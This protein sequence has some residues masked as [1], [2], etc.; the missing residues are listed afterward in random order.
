MRGFLKAG[1]RLRLLR[2]AADPDIGHRGFLE[3]GGARLIWDAV[4]AAGAPSI[5]LGDRLYDVLGEEA[6][7]AFVQFTF[8]T[9][10]EDYIAARQSD[11]LIQD[12][13][14]AELFNHLKTREVRLLKIAADH[15]GLIFEIGGCHP[16]YGLVRSGR[17][18]PRR[19]PSLP[20]ALGGG[21]MRPINSWLRPC[22]PCTVILN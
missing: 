9:A 14:I 7:Y 16:G 13:I 4:E 21:S 10:T 6:A 12:R 19:S 5:H 8:K 22:C 20:N 18:V 1:P 2:W 15:A 17:W 11:G 3:L